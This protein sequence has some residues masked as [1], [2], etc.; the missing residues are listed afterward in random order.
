MLFFF[1]FFF[2]SSRFCSII[3]IIHSFV[4]GPIIPALDLYGALG[5]A[6][7]LQFAVFERREEDNA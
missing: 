7:P 2:F 5:S 6:F 4:G 1:V 3:L